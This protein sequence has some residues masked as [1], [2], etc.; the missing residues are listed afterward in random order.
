L[1]GIAIA[2]RDQRLGLPSLASF[3]QASVSLA[4]GVL[5]HPGKAESEPPLYEI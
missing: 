5:W 1:L 3:H 2:T 4:S